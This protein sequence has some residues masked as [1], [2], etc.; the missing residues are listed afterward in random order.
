MPVTFDVKIL[1]HE[2]KRAYKINKDKCIGCHRCARECPVKCIAGKPKEKHEID[3]N[4]CIACGTCFK[5]C[6]VGAVVEPK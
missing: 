5:T 6:P 2:V 3:E 1:R 4:K